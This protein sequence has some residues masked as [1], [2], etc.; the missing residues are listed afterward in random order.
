[1]RY[2]SN[3]EGEPGQGRQHG[4]CKEID[5]GDRLPKP[6]RS[7][8]ITPCTLGARNEAIRFD[9]FHDRFLSFLSPILPFFLLVY[10]ICS[11]IKKKILAKATSGRKGLFW[12]AVQGCSPSWRG[13]PGSGRLKQRV[14]SHSQSRTKQ[15]MLIP[16][17]FSSV[18]SP[19]PLPRD[20]TSHNGQVVPYQLKTRKSLKGKPKGPPDM[21]SP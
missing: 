2:A 11:V 12:L 16:L 10:F 19:G 4:G 9:F 1:M 14:I 7:H 18:Y 17:T 5:T 6:F 13:S 3:T 21:D 15:W 20:R 8:I